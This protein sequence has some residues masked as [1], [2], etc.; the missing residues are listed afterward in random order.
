MFEVMLDIMFEVN[1]LN[2]VMLG[3][4]L[5]CSVCK[6]GVKVVLV[7]GLCCMMYVELNVDSNC[8]VY[9]LFVSVFM[10]GDKVVMVCGNLVQFLVV[11]YGI[12]KV[13]LVWVLINVMFGLD[14]V[15]YI[16][17]Y[18]EVWYVVIDVVLYLVLCD[19]L[20]VLGLLV[21]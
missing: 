6:F 9:V 14:D 8:Y 3:D 21:Y 20:N 10:F 19:M 5:Y 16:F 4:M 13:G 18:V 11:V 17:E 12:F 15:C 7:D 1:L 2:W